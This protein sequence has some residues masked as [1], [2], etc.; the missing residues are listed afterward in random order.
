MFEMTVIYPN[1]DL[2][3]YYAPERWMLE[4]Q[5]CDMDG[6]GCKFYIEDISISGPRN[7]TINSNLLESLDGLAHESTLC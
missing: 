3:T 4:Q 6:L 5:A 2:E 1:A 7:R